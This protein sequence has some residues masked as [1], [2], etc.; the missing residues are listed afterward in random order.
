MARENDYKKSTSMAKQIF[1]NTLSVTENRVPRSIYGP[2]V[3]DS[4]RGLHNEQLHL[5]Y[6]PNIIRMKKK[7]KTKVMRWLC[8]N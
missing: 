3:E 4:N 2:Q 1:R 6:L 7:K 8:S 5:C